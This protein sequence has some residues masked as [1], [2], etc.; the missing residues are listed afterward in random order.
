LRRPV[1]F[2]TR[3]LTSRSF[4]LVT[5][6]T[7]SGLEGTGY[8]YGG[9]LI[10][11]AV[12]LSLAPVVLGRDANAI[13][14]LWHAMYQEALLL[15]RRGVVLR[16]ISALDIALWDILGK[17]ANMPLAMLLGSGQN[18]V[19]CYFSG[20]YYRDDAT[21]DDIAA[22]AERA[23]AGGFTSM[24]IKIGR[25]P[26]SDLARARLCRGVL[27]DGFPLALDAN[28]AWRDVAGAIRALKPYIELDPWWIEE[29]LSPDDVHGHAELC[30][31]LDAPIA[32]GEIEATRWG[33]RALVE[34]GAADILQPDA[35]VVG[36]IS[37]WLK[38]AHLAAASNIPVAPHWNADVH[39]HLAAATNNCLAV[40]YF[41]LA[42]DVYNFDLLLA[43][44]LIV[45]DGRLQVP[46]RPGVGLALDPEAVARY[47][48][49]CGTHG[50]PA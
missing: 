28:N 16:A 41:S 38:V 17:R 5:V 20:G 18:D 48:V 31:R 25:E 8:S 26:K 36:G 40:E 42:E 46:D 15:G 32:T 9:E 29:P 21:E 50:T 3:R 35:S 2:S 47:T 7:E 4:C 14:E 13:E 12:H 1:A 11:H 37:E 39:V 22:E 27:G 6:R 19:P 30:R 45:R 43:E 33:F 23:L 24:K 44:H 10:A 34:A 49:W